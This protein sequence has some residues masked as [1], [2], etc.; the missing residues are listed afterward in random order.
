MNLYHGSN[1][2]FDSIDL[3]KSKDRRDFGRGFYTTTIKE[4]VQ[5]WGYNMYNRLGGDGIYLASIEIKKKNIS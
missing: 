1:H 4:Q 5:Q 3:S 2:D